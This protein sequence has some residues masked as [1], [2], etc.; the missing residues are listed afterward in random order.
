MEGCQD[1]ACILTYGHPANIPQVVKSHAL[2]FPAQVPYHRRRS[3]SKLETQACGCDD[4]IC[5]LFGCSGRQLFARG[6]VHRAADGGTIAPDCGSRSHLH[7]SSAIIMITLDLPSIPSTISIPSSPRHP[8][9]PIREYNR[10]K[11]ICFPTDLA[12]RPS[13]KIASANALMA[14]EG[15]RS[16]MRENAGTIELAD[17]R[18]PPFW[19]WA[20]EGGVV[21]FFSAF[22]ILLCTAVGCAGV[23]IVWSALL[24]YIWMGIV[25]FLHKTQLRPKLVCSLVQWERSGSSGRW[26]IGAPV[27]FPFLLASMADVIAIA[28]Y[29]ITDPPITSAAHLAAVVLGASTATSVWACA[30]SC[31]CC[32]QI[33]PSNLEEH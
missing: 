18:Q 11:S 17:E 16:G 9:F 10:N 25:L 22:Q 7:H 4:H 27:W 5:H 28:A 29:A 23:S 26:S 3:D 12:S 2:Y 15:G 13:I 32:R 24:G 31:G 19:W 8:H 30:T 20:V 33:S 14:P 6:G 1:I 21:C